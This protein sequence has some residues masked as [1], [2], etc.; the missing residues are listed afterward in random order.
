ML[1]EWITLFGRGAFQSGPVFLNRSAAK[2]IR[3]AAKCIR[4]AAKCNRPAAKLWPKRQNKNKNRE[5]LKCVKIFVQKA[6]KKPKYLLYLF[7]Q[8]IRCFCFIHLPSLPDGWLGYPFEEIVGVLKFENGT[9][10]CMIWSTDFILF[11]VHSLTLWWHF[12]DGLL[13]KDWF[14]IFRD[15]KLDLIPQHPTKKH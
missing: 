2:C 14:V 8:S 4:P 6:K 10:K 7:C 1:R 13:W 5:Q 3:P 9:Y 11:I 15:L 12:P